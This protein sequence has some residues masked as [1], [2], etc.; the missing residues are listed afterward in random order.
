MGEEQGILSEPRA[1]ASRLIVTGQVSH[2]QPGS[3]AVSTVLAFV[4]RLETGEQPVRRVCEVGEAWQ[5]LYRGWLDSC[6]CL[7]IHNH[8]GEQLQRIPSAEER[9]AIDARV[10]ELSF[11]WAKDGQSNVLHA[12]ASLLCFPGESMGPICPAELKDILIRCR[13]GKAKITI[14]MVPS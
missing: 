8:E 3:D 7:T 12:D 6:S 14:N 1:A 9:Q 2:Q 11:S 10:V 4:R 5:P 13:S